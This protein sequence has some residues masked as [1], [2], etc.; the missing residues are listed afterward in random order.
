MLIPFAT[1]PLHNSYIHAQF[2]SPLTLPTLD[3]NT[4]IART[5]LTAH[6]NLSEA[7]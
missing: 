2:Q 6:Y 7:F 5:C 3:L 4:V 1:F